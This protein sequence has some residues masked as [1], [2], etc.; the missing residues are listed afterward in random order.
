M[1]HLAPRP[2]G[3]KRV[4]SEKKF[5][6][7][8]ALGLSELSGLSG[9]FGAFRGLGSFWRLFPALFGFP[10]PFFSVF[11]LFLTGFDLPTCVSRPFR[12]LFFRFLAAFDLPI[13]VSR[14]LRA[15]F[16]RLA[17]FP[18]SFTQTPLT[19]RQFRFRR[20]RKKE[21]QNLAIYRVFVHSD[22]SALTRKDDEL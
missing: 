21:L 22:T 3:P 1:G 6:I 14:P 8:P 20:P 18:V 9:L 11:S 2:W 15:L 5:S 19:S 10:V 16:F 13:C 12:A 4:P 17:L 7:G